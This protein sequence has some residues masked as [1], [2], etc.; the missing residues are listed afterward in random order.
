MKKSCLLQGHI[1][2]SVKKLWHCSEQHQTTEMAQYIEIRLLCSLIILVGVVCTMESTSLQ[3]HGAV[4]L[5]ATRTHLAQHISSLIAFIANV[6]NYLSQRYVVSQAEKQMPSHGSHCHNHVALGTPN[7]LDVVGCDIAV[8]MDHNSLLQQSQC[9]QKTCMSKPTTFDT[10]CMQP[11]CSK[12]Q[13]TPN[14]MQNT[15]REREAIFPTGI[16]NWLC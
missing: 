16:Q 4:L 3:S 8:K 9:Y 13:T 12:M 5:N 11:T 15:E 10:N 14:H 7:S 2:K 6:N 1:G